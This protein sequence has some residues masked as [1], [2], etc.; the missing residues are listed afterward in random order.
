MKC[1]ALP[2]VLR[3][4]VHD[5]GASE[6]IAEEE[7]EYRSTFIPLP[8]DHCISRGLL[9]LGNDMG[10]LSSNESDLKC[11]MSMSRVYRA[12]WL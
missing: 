8:T 4:L 2:E 1:G 9:L 12:E 5:S 3:Q 10:K 6:I 11:Q 7:V